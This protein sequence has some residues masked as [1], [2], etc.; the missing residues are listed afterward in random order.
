MWDWSS[1]R[2]TGSVH[3]NIP[4]T[5]QITFARLVNELHEQTVMLAEISKTPLA[6]THVS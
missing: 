2:K 3:L 6:L 1:S 4:E 5:E